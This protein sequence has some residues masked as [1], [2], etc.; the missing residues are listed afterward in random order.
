MSIY[1]VIYERDPDGW[2]IARIRAVPGVHSNG[3]TI[4]EARRRVREALSLAVD[5]ADG[6]ELVDDVRLP[7]ELRQL[8]RDQQAAR[9]HAAR[10]QRLATDLER[11]AARR[12]TDE[13]NLSLRDVGALLGVS[14]QMIRK[15]V[16]G[17]G[18]AAPNETAVGGASLARDAA[19][20][21]AHRQG[22]RRKR[23]AT[24]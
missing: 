20:N 12:L 23:H 5:D 16:H 21:T 15:L 18:E 11:T 13:M 19:A 4:E 6:A 14:H 1:K 17:S 9:A 8:V 10:E 22:A 3:R 7:K 24:R 2:W